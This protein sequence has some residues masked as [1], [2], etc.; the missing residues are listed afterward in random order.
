VETA[1]WY[2]ARRI[3]SFF[4]MAQDV[5]ERLLELRAV[6]RDGIV[7]QHRFLSRLSRIVAVPHDLRERA[8]LRRHRR[9]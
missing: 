5:D 9:G 6:L 3:V 2:Y 4:P 7:R 1:R 8:H